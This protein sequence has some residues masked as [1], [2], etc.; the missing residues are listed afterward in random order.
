MIVLGIRFV[1]DDETSQEL[2][3]AIHSAVATLPIGIGIVG[4]AVPTPPNG[5][6]HENY[7]RFDSNGGGSREQSSV[8]TVH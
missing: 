6:R 2:A 3:V 5:D 4:N 7:T 8:C 1:V